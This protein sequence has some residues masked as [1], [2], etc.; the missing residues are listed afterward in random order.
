MSEQGNKKSNVKGEY[1]IGV[2]LVV[3]LIALLIYSVS[4]NNTTEV[5]NTETSTPS[6]VIQP[7]E[8][9]DMNTK[10]EAD[11]TNTI[12]LGNVEISDS[13]DGETAVQLQKIQDYLN[14]IYKENSLVYLVVGEG[15][16]DII[17]QFYNS[18]YQC[19]SETSN[20]IVGIYYDR[21]KSI[22]ISDIVAREED[23]TAVDMLQG[24]L[25]LAKQNIDGV[26][27]TISTDDI[28]ETKETD[29]LAETTEATTETTS[30]E[31]TTETTTEETT[32]E[33]SVEDLEKGEFL[34]TQTKT[35]IKIDGMDNIKK[36]YDLFGENF[37]KSMLESWKSLMKDEDDTNESLSFD[38]ITTSIDESLGAGAYMTVDNQEYISWYFENYFPFEQWS[39]DKEDWKKEHTAQELLDMTMTVQNKIT[40]IV[41]TYK[42]DLGISVED[43]TEVSTEAVA[44]SES[45]TETSSEE[46]SEDTTEV[47][48]EAAETTEVSN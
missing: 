7:T 40:D 45:T 43:T 19:Y 28:Y 18:D 34:Y 15:E 35:S 1:I 26:T 46:T 22:I 41:N 3:V 33:V 14:N 16:S 21:A 29:A 5:N 11:N 30:E 37:S 39:V 42:K 17:S 6:E 32:A 27:I 44:T 20:N 10:I 23:A 4:K 2:I 31:T 48:T 36:F 8:V 38:I 47:S 13:L 9:F 12:T 24:A 25:D